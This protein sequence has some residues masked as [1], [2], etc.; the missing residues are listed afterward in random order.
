MFWAKATTVAFILG[1]VALIINLKALLAARLLTTMLL[2]FGILVWIPILAA[3]HH[4]HFTWSE[5]VETFAITGVAWILADLL[6]GLGL[7]GR[8]SS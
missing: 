5:T 8:T 2:L 1:A 4:S 7:R 6:G 3:G